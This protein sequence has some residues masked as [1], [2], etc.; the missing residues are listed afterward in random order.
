MQSRRRR[1]NNKIEDYNWLSVDLQSSR[2]SVLSSMYKSKLID[3]VPRTY[4]AQP[5]DDT[6]GEMFKEPQSS[7]GAG[8][9]TRFNIVQPMQAA[10]IDPNPFRR[11][12]MQA[13]NSP[14]ALLPTHVPGWPL[15]PQRGLP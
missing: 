7:S 1:R 3:D 13:L 12:S 14:P 6:H 9:A 4:E 5:K 11:P 15:Q 8:T 10:L 2:S